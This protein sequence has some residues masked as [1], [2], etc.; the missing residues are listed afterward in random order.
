[1]DQSSTASASPAL[2]DWTASIIDRRPTARAPLS[3][4]VVREFRVRVVG[5]D[6]AFAHPPPTHPTSGLGR[7][8]PWKRDVAPQWECKRARKQA[9]GGGSLGFLE[10]A[11]TAATVRCART[12]RTFNSSSTAGGA[13]AG[14]LLR[15]VHPSHREATRPGAAGPARA[16]RFFDSVHGGRGA[17]SRPLPAVDKRWKLLF[18]PE[19]L[20]GRA[21]VLTYV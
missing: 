18:G 3:F 13:R 10:R 12:Q 5:T 1:M 7:R 11:R 17:G 15:A 6:F 16:R 20:K 19:R 21:Y 2:L 8:R 4:F 9:T 14:P